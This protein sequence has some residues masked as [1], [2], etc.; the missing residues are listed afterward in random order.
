M[1][2]DPWKDLLPQEERSEEVTAPLSL[3]QGTAPNQG[4][5]STR[6]ELE[7][8]NTESK[9]DSTTDMTAKSDNHLEGSYSSAEASSNVNITESSEGCS[10]SGSGNGSGTQSQVEPA[11]TNGSRP[12]Y[13][14]KDDCCM[15]PVANT[16]SNET[17]DMKS[18]DKLCL[19]STD[20]EHSQ[21]RECAT[22]NIQD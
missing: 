11:G 3:D 14:Q 1:F 17:K 10:T 15:E 19:T 7:Q 9:I 6:N 12:N 4:G 2:E 8:E 20:Q 21:F 18:R 16:N 13:V 5:T 22:A